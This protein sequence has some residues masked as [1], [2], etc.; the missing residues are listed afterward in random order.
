MIMPPGISRIS[1]MMPIKTIFR[2]SGFAF[3]FF[4][5]SGAATCGV[6]V[7]SGVVSIIVLIFKK[8]F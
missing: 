3:A 4:S 7:I 2:V 6:G 1:M 5:G 8:Y